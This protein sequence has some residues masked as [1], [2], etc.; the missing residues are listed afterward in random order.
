MAESASQRL[1][2]SLERLIQI[3][4]GD[5][6]VT[7]IQASDVLADALG[8]DKVDVFLLD[9]ARESLAAVSSSTQP[10]SALQRRMGLDVMPLANGGRVVWVYQHWQTF[11]TGQLQ[12]DPEELRGIKE[13]L[14][15][16]SKIGVPLAIDERHRGMIMIASLRPDYF[17]AE[18]VRYAEG[19]AQWIGILAHRAELAEETR[20]NAV[21]HSRRAMAEELVAVVAHDLRNHLTP[22]EL[23]LEVLRR[24]S[25]RA[26]RAEEL[27]AEIAQISR[28]LGQLRSLISDLLDV[29]RLDHG[30]FRVDLTPVDLIRLVQE[31]AQALTR[32][33]RVIDVREQITD[34]VMLLGDEGRLRQCLENL[35]VNAIDQ[36]PPG[37]T[38][39]VLIASEKRTAGEYA[40]V[41]VMDE[42]PGVAPEILPRI[43]ERHATTKARGGGLGLGLFL[44]KRIAELHGG[45][46]TVES[47]PGRGAKFEFSVPCYFSDALAGP[48]TNH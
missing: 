41:T 48:A 27:A 25:T 36:S 21:E 40:R 43:F 8:A 20:R 23:R 44:A 37:S 1:L 32:P 42:G 10:L 35:I 18:D 46:L 39:T 30:L 9:P 3:P 4:T 24:L 29:A 6:T 16:C 15:V 19:M 17:S 11:V 28:S 2:T 7:L 12:E 38:V 47:P 14:R 34:R 45:E 26:G 5:L 13:G 31:S 22:I 33:D